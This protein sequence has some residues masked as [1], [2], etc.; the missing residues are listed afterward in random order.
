MPSLV[1]RVIGAAMDVYNEWGPGL[2]EAEY[3]KALIYELDQRGI[4]AESQVEI[5]ILY[6]GCDLGNK[7]RLDLLVEDELIIELKSVEELKPVHFKQLRTYMKILKKPIGILMNFNV[8][9]FAR[10]Y[11]VLYSDK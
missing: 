7:L 3:E 5:D 6:K 10:G 8:D 11:R 2:L 4:S 1:Y 9:D